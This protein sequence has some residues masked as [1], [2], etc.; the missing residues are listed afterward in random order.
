[1]VSEIRTI[2][3]DS[4]ILYSEV[5]TASFIA[6]IN[7]IETSFVTTLSTTSGLSKAAVDTFVT[8][9]EAADKAC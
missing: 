2:V 1:M 5:A 4:S 8:G 7:Q 3:G 9:I 6:Y